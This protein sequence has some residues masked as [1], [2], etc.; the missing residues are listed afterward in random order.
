MNLHQQNPTAFQDLSRPKLSKILT[1]YYF[2]SSFL[3]THAPEADKVPTQHA[4]LTS[5]LG[6]KLHMDKR[7]RTHL[8]R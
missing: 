3:T 5:G 2:Q 7:G 1:F 6:Y 4:G 8:L